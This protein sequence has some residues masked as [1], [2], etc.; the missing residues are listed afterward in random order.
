MKDIKQIVKEPIFFERNRVYRIYEGGAP[1]KEFF[2][3]GFDDGT[4]NFFP[5]EWIASSVKALN[6]EMTSE[7]EGISKV[8][9]TDIYFDELIAKYTEVYRRKLRIIKKAVK[10]ID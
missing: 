10:K 7:Y 4:D 3:D 6:K 9:D 2:G 5:E 1:Y 8:K